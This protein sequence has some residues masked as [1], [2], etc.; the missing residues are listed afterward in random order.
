MPD[1]VFDVGSYPK[2]SGKLSNG[3]ELVDPL[4]DRSKEQFFPPE[5]DNVTGGTAAGLTTYAPV[6]VRNYH[7]SRK[8]QVASSASCSSY[9]DIVYNRVHIEP[10]RLQLGN[11]L[12]QQVRTVSLW[13][14]FLDSSKTLESVDSYGT[15]GIQLATGFDLPVQFSPLEKKTLQVKVTLEGPPSINAGYQ[16]NFT[17]AN[18]PSVTI[19]GDRVVVFSLPP[20]TSKKYSENL[21][22]A[23][24]I[25]TSYNGTEQRIALK[26]SPATSISMT[27]SAVGDN[28]RRFSSLI[29]GWG[30][31]SFALPLW[32]YSGTLE[33]EAL[34]GSIDLLTDV[35][36]RPYK[37]GT[38]VIVFNDPD[39][40]EAVQI[41]EVTENGLKLSRRL[42]RTWDAGS[43]VAP[44]RTGQLPSQ[45]KSNWETA[46]LVRSDL[47]FSLTENEDL[48]SF[49]AVDTYEGYP[50]LNVMPNFKNG[51][52]E[53]FISNF[54]EVTTRTS[55]PDRV[56]RPG[57]GT[58]TWSFK[59]WLKS[60]PTINEFKSWLYRSR[61]AQKLFWV[62]TWKFDLRLVKDIAAGENSITVR[63]LGYQSLYQENIG[64]R[65][66]RMIL[67]DGTTINME[68][69]S[70][71][72][73]VDGLSETLSV[74]GAFT[75]LIKTTDVMMICFM[76]LHRF[77][78]D[79]ISLEW[80]SHE[81]V[82]SE[83]KLRLI[84]HEL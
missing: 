60:L 75:R 38:L 1:E 46:E 21:S 4:Y 74:G 22:W 41:Q 7:K 71:S 17:G 48:D 11:M 18:N 83:T 13:S 9:S 37:A 47:S 27:V 30:Y 66:F 34:K 54:D 70:A 45:I 35:T 26:N 69:K 14:A 53:T 15:D 73:S 23:T 16:F 32:H 81:L 77:D 28:A 49:K 39:N 40:F 84:T 5:R 3:F 6:N 12:S 20:D 36:E 68:I 80:K 67:K 79:S 72:I 59:W 82:E 65:H 51:K 52:T 58:I 64:R 19:S 63:Y 42:E 10:S 62:P 43:V 8:V 50:I 78:S 56:L 57:Q 76:G 55:E 2:A 33:L 44:C 31:R 29:W 25:L 61:G 24:N